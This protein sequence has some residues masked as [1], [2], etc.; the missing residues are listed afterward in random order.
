MIIRTSKSG[1]LI[2]AMLLASGHF[3]SVH[4][5]DGGYVDSVYDWGTWE[6]GIEPAAGGPV[7]V[8]NQPARVNQGGVQFRPNSNASFTTP[9]NIVLTTRD[10]SP[11]PPPVTPTVPSVTPGNPGAGPGIGNVR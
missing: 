11:V 7:S 9:G 5:A 8:G 3:S 4:A 10:N 2:A 6:L 1:A